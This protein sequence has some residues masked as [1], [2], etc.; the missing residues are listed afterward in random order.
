MNRAFLIGA[1]SASLLLAATVGASAQ[2]NAAM[3]QSTSV[4]TEAVLA[5]K[6]QQVA[7]GAAGRM[8]Y[9]TYAWDN[10]MAR[11]G[12]SPSDRNPNSAPTAVADAH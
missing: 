8:P 7:G 9:A 1:A 4:T 12:F 2:S 11:L 3:T 10:M 6:P 5:A